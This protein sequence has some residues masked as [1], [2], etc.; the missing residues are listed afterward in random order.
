M[1]APLYQHRGYGSKIYATNNG[2]VMIAEYHYS[3]GNH[4][5]INHNNGYMT[6]Y[7]HM[8]KIAVKAGQLVA[9][10]QVIGYVGCTGD[11][12]GPH[13]HYEVWKGQKWNH[14]NPSVL[15]PNGYR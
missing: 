8:S 15:Y 14:V 9:K 10:G 7:G 12:T 11:C 5:V 2:R 4:V 6:L 3:Y 1:L 13:V